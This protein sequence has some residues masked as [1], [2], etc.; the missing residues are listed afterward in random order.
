M[1][2]I[3]VKIQLSE[4]KK[5]FWV[6]PLTRQKYQRHSYAQ[7]NTEIIDMEG[8]KLWVSAQTNLELVNE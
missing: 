1:E 8:V 3:K 4:D 7:F 6:L 2:K 5:T